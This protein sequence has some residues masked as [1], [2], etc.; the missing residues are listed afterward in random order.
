M[1]IIVLI[2]H[3]WNMSRFII[4]DKNVKFIFDFWFV[5]VVK[6]N[7]SML[8]FTTYHS[9]ID[10]QFERTNQII[11]I[12]FRFHI[13]AHSND[14]WTKILLYLQIEN[15]NVKQF[16]INYVFNKLTYE[17]KINDAINILVDFLS[18]NY[19]KL[20]L[21]KR[22]NVEIVMT[23]VNV[24][25]KSRYDNK[26]KTFENVIQSKIMI[27]LRLY[28]NYTISRLF[29]KKLS[30]QRVDFY[31]IIEIV[32]KFKQIWRLKLSFVMKIHSIVS[33]A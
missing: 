26:Y 9:Q 8:I 13:I 10:E 25:N 7:I 3:D 19:D 1:I 23:F 32:D 12:I 15:N 18:K 4:N 21:I 30:N 11:E 20:R 27:Y 24:I 6:I 28:Q 29:N 17:F 5:I 22:E 31:K 16:T 33:I 2:D 14:D